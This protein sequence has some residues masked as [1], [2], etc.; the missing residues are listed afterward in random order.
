MVEVTV[1]EMETIDCP[2]H[3]QE[4]AISFY[5]DEDTMKISLSDNTFLTKIKRVIQKNPSDFKIY[6]AGRNADGNVMG[7]NVVCPKKYLTIRSCAVVRNFTE[8]QREAAREHMKNL[9][10]N[11]NSR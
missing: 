3:E 4:V 6:E 1:D 11:K 8:E 7:Y 5:R 9:R 2:K 10:G